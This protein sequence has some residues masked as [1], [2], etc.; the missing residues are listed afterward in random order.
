[1]LRWGPEV[2]C[3]SIHEFSDFFEG[4]KT[5]AEALSQISKPL[6]SIKHVKNRIKLEKIVENLV[7]RMKILRNSEKIREKFRKK[8]YMT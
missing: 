5:I 6:K 2:I 3:L 4:K 8:R 7:I 1:M